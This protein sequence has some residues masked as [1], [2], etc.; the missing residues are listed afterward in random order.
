MV[1]ATTPEENKEI[2]IRLSTEVVI[3][4][5]NIDELMSPDFIYHGP[6]GAPQMNREQCLGF[7]D[8]LMNAFPDLNIT[9]EDVIAEG[10]TVMLRYVT[11]ATH[12]GDFMG[13]PATGTKT[14][15]RGILTRKVIDG[16]VV[17]EWNYTDTL[18]MMKQLGIIPAGK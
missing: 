1:K 11:R 16:K 14:E 7:W 3:L 18:S 4:K 17:E 13:A 12:T 5:K 10:D 15:V 2:A 9:F 6:G 8:T